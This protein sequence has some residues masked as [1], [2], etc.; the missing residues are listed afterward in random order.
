M[1]RRSVK[2]WLLRG[3]LCLVVC[4]SASLC[5]NAQSTA[6]EELVTCSRVK[7]VI[8]S[9]TFVQGEDATF[10]RWVLPAYIVDRYADSA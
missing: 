5:A 4:L 9:G 3:V 1:K 10:H 6:V 8:G 2:T 7:P